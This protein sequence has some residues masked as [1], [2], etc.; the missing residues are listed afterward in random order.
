MGTELLRLEGDLVPCCGT[1]VVWGTVWVTYIGVEFLAMLFVHGGK[2][3]IS[4]LMHW[5]RAAALCWCWFAVKSC[6]HIQ[7]PVYF[8]TLSCFSSVR[9]R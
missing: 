5:E 4:L 9:G 1:G 8:C 7:G 6:L 2:Q 3:Q